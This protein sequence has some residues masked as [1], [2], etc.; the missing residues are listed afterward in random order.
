M[1]KPDLT[2]YTEQRKGQGSAIIS[3]IVFIVVYA[4][5]HADLPDKSANIDE[6]AEQRDG[7]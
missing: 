3:T 2:R 5:S 6:K 1:A 4:Y 7:P